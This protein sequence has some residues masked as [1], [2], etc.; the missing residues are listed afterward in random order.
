MADERSGPGLPG[1]NWIVL[2]IAAIGAFYAAFQTQPFEGF[3]PQAPQQQSRTSNGIQD[4]PARLWQDPLDVVARRSNAAGH[5]S[6]TDLGADS[7]SIVLAVSMPGEFYPED[8]E[9][10]RRTRYAVLSALH[11]QGYVPRDEAHIGYVQLGGKE[12]EIN[13]AATDGVTLSIRDQRAASMERSGR[14]PF[15]WFDGAD[16]K[17]LLVLWLD[18]TDLTTDQRPLRRLARIVCDLG[19]DS[20]RWSFIGPQASTTLRQIVAETADPEPSDHPTGQCDRNRLRHMSV[21]NYGATVADD[22]LESAVSNTG[23]THPRTDEGGIVGTK[24]HALDV[25]YVRT[26][27]TDEQLALAIFEEVKR[28]GVDFG[29]NAASPTPDR[30]LLISEWDS[31]YGRSL[32]ATVERV[33]NTHAPHKADWIDQYSYLRGLDGQLPEQTAPRPSSTAAPTDATAGQS[34]GNGASNLRR[35]EVADGESQYDY[36]RR[37]AANMRARDEQLHRNSAG[38]VAIGVLGSDVYDKLTILQALRPEFPEA[39]FFTTDL[40]ERLRPE[41]KKLF[42]RNL[43]VASGFER[44]LRDAV[45]VDVPPFRGSYETSAFLATRLAVRFVNPTAEDKRSPVDFYELRKTLN[46]W[47]QQ[48]RLFEIGRTKPIPLASLSSEID[49]VP[50]PSTSGSGCRDDLLHCK[51]I[52]PKLPPSYP[53]PSMAALSGLGALCGTVLFSVWLMVSPRRRRFLLIRKLLFARDLAIFVVAGGAV[54]A[55]WPSLGN[56]LSGDGV[57][58]PIYLFE[59]VS[60]WPSTTIRIFSIILGSAMSIWALRLSRRNLEETHR[61]LAISGLFKPARRPRDLGWHRIRNSFA[62]DFPER[63]PYQERTFSHWLA[64]NLTLQPISVKYPFRNDPERR[65]QRIE[66]LLLR[67]NYCG[68]WQARLT[69]AAVAAAVMFAFWVILCMIFGW[70]HNFARSSVSKYLYLVATIMDVVTT[71]FLIFIVV[72]ATLYSKAFIRCLTVAQSNWPEPTKRL[73]R[74]RFKMTDTDLDDWIDL[75]FMALRTTVITG[76]VYFP[77]VALA[78]LAVARNTIFANFSISWPIIITS[79]TSVAIIVGSVYTLR[80]AAEEARSSARALVMS[81]QIAAKEDATR[82]AQLESLLGLIDDLRVGAFAPWSSQP[83]VR[84]GVLP[85]LTYGGTTL[86]QLYALPGG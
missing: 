42:S 26:T 31:S 70:P 66:W 27:N 3:R 38:V 83:I 80:Q 37:L 47:L 78:V 28:R 50:T 7:T 59:V 60:L 17:P 34:N 25:D 71:L 16:K 18:E 36:L 52:H 79:L 85:L 81:R 10:R 57:G 84:A 77:F 63:T 54:S 35:R 19:L 14:I 5:H 21:F 65:F 48:P 13:I 82:A 4:I 23:G 49:Y 40:D 72:D 32:P 55:V 20:N 46:H 11:A 22:E 9:T 12:R 61:A 30:L 45:Q 53:Q 62:L 51:F 1:G 29:E 15:E 64:L 41:G 75:Q 58:E 2:A 69:R 33:F 39:L 24:L 56:L 44:R 43:I 67:F 76:L 6:L 73:F 8:S 68:R 86:L 74:Q